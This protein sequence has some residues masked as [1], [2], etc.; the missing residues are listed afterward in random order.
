ML[1]NA[2]GVGGW[3]ISRKRPLRTSKVYGAMLLALRG[4]G[5]VSIFQKKKHHVTLEWP[6][7][8]LESLVSSQKNS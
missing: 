1:R 7:M 4:G 5:C 2:I 8:I 6:Q 3:Q